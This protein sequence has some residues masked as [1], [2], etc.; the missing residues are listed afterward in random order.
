[1]PV[2]PGSVVVALSAAEC[3]AGTGGSS[4][5]S[6]LL[7]TTLGIPAGKQWAA[8]RTHGVHAGE[9]NRST[10]VQRLALQTSTQTWTN[11]GVKLRVLV[12]HSK[13]FISEM[14]VSQG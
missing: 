7:R 12:G 8:V 9:T 6:R 10:A 11:L 13:V 4:V 3:V 14:R 5:V 1:M 2:S